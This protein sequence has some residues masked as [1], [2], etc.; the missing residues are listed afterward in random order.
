MSGTIFKAEVLSIGSAIWDSST[1]GRM[2]DRV[3]VSG[4]MY[5][6]LIRGTGYAAMMYR[7]YI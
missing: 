6:W 2:Y 5:V 4:L 3:S 1:V 7:V